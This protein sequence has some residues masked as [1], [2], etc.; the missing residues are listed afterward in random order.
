MKKISLLIVAMGLFIVVN[1][2]QASP[3]DELQP[4]STIV[5][6]EDLDVRG[7]G[8][9]QS[10]RVGQQSTGGVTFFNGTIINETKDYDG[11]DLPVTVG[12]DMRIDGE[13][14][15]TEVGGDDPI[16]LADTIRPQTTAAYDLGLSTNKFRHGYFS[17]NVSV[18]NLVG[19]EVVNSANIADSTITG[20]DIDSTTTI[21]A[22]NFAYNS[23]K[24]RYLTIGGCEFNP[25]DESDNWVCDNN[26]LYTTDDEYN[27]TVNL[28][29]SAI[30]TSLK[31]YYIDNTNLAYVQ[32]KLYRDD[33]EGLVDSATS[34]NV[35]EMASASSQGESESTNFRAA[36]DTSINQATIRNDLYSYRVRLDFVDMASVSLGVVGVRVGYE[37]SQPN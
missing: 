9:F 7:T 35:T 19:S 3:V 10:I 34:P 29:Q 2:V 26:Y 22:N 5:Y 12:D 4:A 6:S 28:P 21:T 36:T 11:N 1:N 17:G 18:G 14:F 33:L 30:V 13:L 20:D 8:T 27:A 16:K 23:N 31:L 32:A 24:T 25:E 15:R 37:V